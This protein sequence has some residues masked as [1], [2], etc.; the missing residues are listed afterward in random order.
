M[1]G[2]PDLLD[3][4]SGIRE[5][6]RTAADGHAVRLLLGA[7]PDLGPAAEPARCPLEARPQ[8]ARSRARQGALELSLA[9]IPLPQR[10]FDR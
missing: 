3:N 9:F 10:L 4:L 5:L 2:R 8:L 6:V 7:A 1:P